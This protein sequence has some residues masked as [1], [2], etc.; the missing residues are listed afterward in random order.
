[1]QPHHQDW[2]YTYCFPFA[3]S[4][5]NFAQR[6]FVAFEILALAAAD[7]TRFV[8]PVVLPVVLPLLLPAVLPLLL[9][10][11]LALLPVP[12]KSLI[13]ARTLSTCCC[14]ALTSFSHFASSSFTA[15]KTSIRPPGAC[16][17]QE[18]FM[19]NYPVVF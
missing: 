16:L 5:L 3:F 11:A 6:S 2:N 1:M 19:I 8:L 9:P 18:Q 13:A 17:S 7:I 10:V 12:P 14:A 4:A 15:A